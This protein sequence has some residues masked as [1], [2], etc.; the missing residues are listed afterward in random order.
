MSARM[1]PVGPK[2]LS[3][4]LQSGSNGNCIYV[5]A[6]GVRLLFDAGISAALA[7][8]RLAARGRELAGVDAIIISHEH[9][10]H[11]RGAGVI[12]RKHGIPLYISTRTQRRAAGLLGRVE[13]PIAFEPGGRIEIGPLVI[14]TLRT[15]HDAVEPVC[16]V[17]EHAGARLGILTDLG[18]A[19]GTLARV[20]TDLDAAY[21]ESN[22][23]PDMLETGPYAEALKRRVRGPSGHLSNFEAADLARAGARGRLR[24]LTLAHLSE[25]NNEPELALDTHRRALGRRFPIRVASRHAVGDVLE[26]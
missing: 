24:W 4:S 19:F 5:E 17:L 20:L 9:D 18:H 2:V 8:L 12:H 3:F 11:V 14:H 13:P 26:L 10:D 16:F 22:Y 15:P 6:G 1:H 21:L 7:E 25:V 23:D